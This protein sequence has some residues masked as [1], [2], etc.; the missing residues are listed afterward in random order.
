VFLIF[1]SHILASI[2]SEERFNTE[3]ICVIVY[4]TRLPVIFFCIYFYETVLL[5][6]LTKRVVQLK[7]IAVHVCV[8]VSD[9]LE[10][11]L[12]YFG[13]GACNFVSFFQKIHDFFVTGPV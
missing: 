10:V 6:A 13:R 11:E 4:V 8:H 3:I 5:G 12:F 1:S 9:V 7:Y 2:I